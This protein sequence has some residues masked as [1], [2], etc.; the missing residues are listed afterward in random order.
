[1]IVSQ[2]GG[3]AGGGR[4]S[5]A[6]L[7]TLIDADARLD[8]ARR[9]RFLGAIRTVCTVLARPAE[10]ISAEPGEIERLL[11][12]VPIPARRV[13]RKTIANLR[14]SLKAALRNYQQIPRIPP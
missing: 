14:S 9:G 6:E 10:A 8:D 11:N 3:L 7:V 2:T 5:L 4:V 12:Q 13:S 1:M